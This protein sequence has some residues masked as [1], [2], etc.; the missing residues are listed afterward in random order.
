MADIRDPFTDGYMWRFPT[1][2]HWYLARFYERK[3][4]QYAD[5]VIVNTPEV[6]KGFSLVI[7]KDDGRVKPLLV[8]REIT[9]HNFEY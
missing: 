5:K 6:E 9:Y 1:K 2:L 7:V 3:M 4:L 8:L